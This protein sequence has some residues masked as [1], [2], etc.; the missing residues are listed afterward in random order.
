MRFAPSSP[1]MS[2]G[3]SHVG[4]ELGFVNR[5]Q[6]LD[7]LDSVRPFLSSPLLLFSASQCLGGSMVETADHSFAASRLNRRMFGGWLKLRALILD[8]VEHDKQIAKN[9]HRSGGPGGWGLCLEA[10]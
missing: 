2:L 8:G 5:Q 6:A 7:R 10:D 9:R 4:P 1:H 3:E